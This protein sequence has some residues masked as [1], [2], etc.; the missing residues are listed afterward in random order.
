MLRRVWRG[1]GLEGVTGDGGATGCLEATGVED[2]QGAERAVLHAIYARNLSR[3]FM[4]HANNVIMAG[5]GAESEDAEH[6]LATVLAR[7]GDGGY[8]A[9]GTSRGMICVVSSATGKAEVLEP[10]LSQGRRA[11]SDG[12]LTALAIGTVGK[13]RDVV[14]VGAGF[15]SGVVKMWRASHRSG[16]AGAQGTTRAGAF[17]PSAPIVDRHASGIVDLRVMNGFEKDVDGVLLSFDGYGRVVSHL[18]PKLL[19]NGPGVAAMMSSG[20][21]SQSIASLS[22]NIYSSVSSVLRGTSL[23]LPMGGDGLNAAAGASV[24]NTALLEA[25]GRVRR[26][27]GTGTRARKDMVILLTEKAGL[28]VAEVGDGGTLGVDQV[29]GFGWDADWDADGGG[30]GD[31]DGTLVAACLKG[32]QTLLVALVGAS[33]AHV[34]MVRNVST[35]A[36]VRITC[37]GAVQDVLFFHQ[38][39]FAGVVHYDDASG[40]TLMTLVP[41]VGCVDKAPGKVSE[42]SVLSDDPTPLYARHDI[43]DIYVKGSAVGGDQ[44]SDVIL[45]TSSGVRCVQLMSW[46][47]KL[48]SMVASRRFEEALMHSMILYV[49][50]GGKECN[51]WPANEASDATEVS[52]Q[53]MSLLILYLQQTM[54]HRGTDLDELSARTLVR[55]MLDVCS[56]VSEF[57]AF[58]LDLPPLLQRSEAAWQA[59]LDLVLEHCQDSAHLAGNTSVPPQIV[60]S[61]VERVASSPDRAEK[62]GLLEDVLLSFE[63]SSLDLNQVLPLCIK[64]GLYSVLIYVFTR[65]MKD[66]KSPASLLVATAAA[67]PACSATRRGLVMK[68]LVYIYA[69]FEGL[70]YPLGSKETHLDDNNDSKTTMRLDMMDFLLFASTAEIREAVRL[71]ESLEATTDK[72]GDILALLEGFQS[73]VLAFL[74]EE[75]AQTTLGLL[76]NLLSGWDG[77]VSDLAPAGQPPCAQR[78]LDADSTLSQVTVDR[79]ISLLDDRGGDA[80]S[81]KLDF[82]AG[83][84]SSSRASLPP[85]ASAAVLA[86]LGRSISDVNGESSSE[87]KQKLRNNALDIVKHAPAD[88]L[89]DDLLSL[90]RMAGSAAAEAEI[91]M[92]RGAYHDAIRCLMSSEVESRSI[93][94]YYR[95]IAGRGGDCAAAFQKAVLPNF[96]KLVEVD[97]AAVAEIAVDLAGHQ[98]QEII[99]SFE[100]DSSAQFRFLNAVVALLRHRAAGTKDAERRYEASPWI[101]LLKSKAMSTMY[102]RLMCRFDPESVLGYLQRADYDVEECLECCRANG[103]RGAQAFLLDKMGDLDAAFHMYLEDVEKINGEM[104]AC[105]RPEAQGQLTSRAETACDAA[106]SLCARLRSPDV[107]FQGPLDHP[108][109]PALKYKQLVVAYVRSYAENRESMPAWA[110]AVLTSQIKLVAQRAGNL[111]SI[112]R[113]VIDTFQDVPTRDMKDVLALLLSV[114]EFEATKV[115]L[116]AA[117]AQRDVSAA[118]QTAYRECSMGR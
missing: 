64:Y 37:P 67:E 19:G 44:V 69:C 34:V 60:Q 117:I 77:L 111:E 71:W 1:L 28:V 15:A 23:A 41:T 118:L 116:A 22:S 40:K 14:V 9:V 97:A 20:A 92:R 5:R 7:S 102:I 43:F 85:K 27:I 52:K 32:D 86:A 88:E 21:Y 68:L 2:G 47:Q 113:H 106:V 6:G 78:A 8:V 81:A 95:D 89:N 110:K 75:A 107:P 84:I 33:S 80:N 59:Y 62:L 65:G 35:D 12:E 50:N 91:L 109:Q 79:V 29:V 16:P 115:K 72:D 112:V 45:L 42:I 74:C 36:V 63:V 13:A 82:V 24:L 51:G 4:R 87:R 31:A 26:V 93:F 101:T 98:H 61:L 66:F 105:S 76:Q 96:P 30:D 73:P 70:S 99:E 38:G 53:V 55:L 114:G 49:D 3:G 46:K 103:L 90:A 11:G 83:L 10:G 56:L 48:S 25:V 94:A 58:Y 18:V 108:E 17:V 104:V 39:V 54:E 100:K 57:S